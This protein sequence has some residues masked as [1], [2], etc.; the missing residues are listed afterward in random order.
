MKFLPVKTRRFR[1]PRDDIYD[2][3]KALPR[4]RNKD[5]VFITS[6]VLAIHQ[7]R[8]VKIGKGTLQEKNRL[9]MSEADW[10][11][12]PSKRPGQHWHLTI[13]NNT[14][15]G[16]A[17][18]DTSNG[19]GYYILWPRNP[20][21]LAKEIRNYLK[22]KY[23]LKQLAVLVIDSHLFPLRAG[24][25]GIS[26]AFFGLEPVI[27]YRG[28]PDIF[29]KKLEVTQA[30]IV[31]S[32]A[33][34]ANLFMGEGKEQTP[35]LVARGLKFIKFTNKDTNRKSLISPKTDIFSPLLK[36]YRKNR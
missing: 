12:P 6:K 13:K 34:A 31:D 23:R 18:I 11:V 4:L 14:L 3:L 20:K 24:T 16:D 1:P 35:V 7:G 9:I 33:A 26:I 19:N 10:Y 25:I 5:V 17:G 21:K 2:L 29:G 32:L 36:V 27:D 8:S 28:K 15:I 30:N 22:R